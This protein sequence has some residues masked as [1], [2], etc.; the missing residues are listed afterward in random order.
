M[1]RNQHE[2]V[3]GTNCDFVMRVI[4][5]WRTNGFAMH[6]TDADVEKMIQYPKTMKF[7]K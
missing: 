6:I 5:R 2:K 1:D 7:T 3:D 4:K